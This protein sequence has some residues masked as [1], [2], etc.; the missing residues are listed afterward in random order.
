MSS[1]TEALYRIAALAGTGDDPRAALREILEILLARFE[2]AS[3]SI[4]LLNPDTGR[5]VVEVQRGLPPDADD[6]SLRLGQGVTGWVAFHGKPQFL[7]DVSAD[8]RYI[9]IRP[10][11]RS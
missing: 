7:P 4:S 5:L 6:L 1:P 2:A 9:R 8:L 11:A 10:E 3:G